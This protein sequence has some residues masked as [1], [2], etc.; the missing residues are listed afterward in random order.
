MPYRAALTRRF[1][2]ELMRQPPDIKERALKTID[3]IISEP[4]SGTKLRGELEGRWR[5]RIGEYRIIYLI[6]DPHRLVV[7][8]DVGPRKSIYE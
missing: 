3:E 5:W 1:L 6:D 4:F 7:F 2:R 8:L